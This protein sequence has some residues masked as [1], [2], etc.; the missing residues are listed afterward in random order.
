M[1]LLQNKMHGLMPE[2]VLHTTPSTTERP[3][4][5]TADYNSQSSERSISMTAKDDSTQQPSQTLSCSCSSFILT[6]HTCPLLHNHSQQYLRTHHHN[7]TTILA[8]YTYNTKP[9]YSALVF[10]VMTTFL[11]PWF[12]YVFFMYLTFAFLTLFAHRLTSACTLTSILVQILDLSA[13][14]RIKTLN[15]NCHCLCRLTSI[16]IW[17]VLFPILKNTIACVVIMDNIIKKNINM[18]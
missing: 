14:F 13:C 11:V 18:L 12:L 1:T 16:T 7:F 4:S 17:F 9:C 8:K 5:M 2:M 6:T 3:T 15:L 10:M